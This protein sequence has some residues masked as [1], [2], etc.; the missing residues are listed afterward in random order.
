MY[1]ACVRVRTGDVRTRRIYI[2]SP[3]ILRGSASTAVRVRMRGIIGT[4]GQVVRQVKDVGPRTVA[5]QVTQGWIAPRHQP[6]HEK[7]KHVLLVHAHP[8]PGSFSGA[9]AAAVRSGLEAGG[10]TVTQLNLYEQNFEPCLSADERR[11]YL[12]PTTEKPRLPPYPSISQ[13]VRPHVNA[14]QTH[15]AIVFVYPTWWFNVPAVLKGWLDRVFLPGVAFKLPHLEPPSSPVRGGLVP[16]LDHVKKMG[17]VSTYGSPRHIANTCGD[18]GRNMLCRAVLP[19]FAIDCTVHY[20][21]LY[22]MDSNQDVTRVAFLDRVE[23]YY[24]NDFC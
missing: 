20:H 7:V 10:A 24:R 16:C 23:R 2:W 14:L 12:G 13:D 6:A 9:L 19:L 5:N 15:D 21:G 11:R 22:E 8:L 17:I 18:N 1:R 3:G 4:I